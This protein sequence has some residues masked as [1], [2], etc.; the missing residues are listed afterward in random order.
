MYGLILKPEIRL[1][2]DI[3]Q[4]VRVM[5]L[6]YIKRSVPSSEGIKK[7]AHESAIFAVEN[8]TVKV[9]KSLTELLLS[10][11]EWAGRRM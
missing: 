4:A 6:M 10:D 5:H 3:H 9:S 1:Q 2:F 11:R 7:I 8:E